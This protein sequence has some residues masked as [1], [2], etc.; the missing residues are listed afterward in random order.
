MGAFTVNVGGKEYDVDAP[1]ETTAWKWA[2][3]THMK[4]IAPETGAPQPEEQSGDPL[5]KYS[6]EAQQRVK[7]VTE[8]GWGS[9][10]PQA[11]YE[12]GGKVTDFLSQWDALRGKPAA[13]AGGATNFILNAIPAFLGGG[14][15]QGAAQTAASGIPRWL[16]KSALKAPPTT[17]PGKVQRAVGTL[18]E[19]GYSP[20]NAGVQAMSGRVKDLGAQVDDIIAPLKRAIPVAPVAQGIEASS[21]GAQAGTL[22]ARSADTARDVAKALYAH[23]AVDDAGTMSVQAAQAMK[24]ANYRELGDAAYG[25]GL[26]PA[27][28]R[29]ALKAAARALREGVE[30][31]APA[32]RAPNAKQQELINALKLSTRR[33]ATE[34][35]KD[36]IPLGASVATSVA[37]PAAALGLYANSSAA[38]KAALAR[39]LYSGGKAAGPEARAIATYLNMMEQEGR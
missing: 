38:I 28:E 26:K 39:A 18:L 20:T 23:P 11:T 5:A 34:A 35:N 15:V 30:S 3:A 21:R 25:M 2:R 19:E 27:A 6:Q 16:M 10:L 31:V 4:T 13:A 24:K 22:G 29:D 8:R 36:V 9:G 37:N 33:A 7:D 32:V 1:D 12:A 14:S 17:D